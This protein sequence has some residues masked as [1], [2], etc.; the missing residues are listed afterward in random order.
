MSP[1][2]SPPSPEVSLPEAKAPRMS[3]PGSVAA[4]TTSPEYRS[5][6]GVPI[7]NRRRTPIFRRFRIVHG[8]RNGCLEGRGPYCKCRFT[9]YRLILWFLKMET[10]LTRRLRTLSTVDCGIQ[11]NSLSFS[12]VCS[13]LA[14]FPT[15]LSTISCTN[16]SVSPVPHYDTQ[17]EHPTLIKSHS[18][19]YT[20][21]GNSDQFVGWLIANSYQRLGGIFLFFY[22]YKYI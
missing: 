2:H 7:Q 3:S 18:T 19:S 16:T 17:L 11:L 1:N 14:L 15:T 13:R 5:R 22:F 9:Q 6:T 20:S 21:F 4:I 12:S 8:F 10:A